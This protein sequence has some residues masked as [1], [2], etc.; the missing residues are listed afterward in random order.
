MYIII[1][2]HTYLDV[3]VSI[4]VCVCVYTCAMLTGEMSAELPD[5]I[6]RT[7]IFRPTLSEYIYIYVCV[8]VCGSVI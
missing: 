5:G 6:Y 4:R 2:S 8:H 1:T 7:S 3:Y